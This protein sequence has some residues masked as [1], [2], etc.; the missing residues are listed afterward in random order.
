MDRPRV[1]VT[2]EQCWHDVPGGT[3]TSALHT[4]AALGAAGRFEPIGVSARHTSPPAEAFRPSVPVRP[5]PLPRPALYES[6]HRLRR[7]SLRRAV[8]D[9]AVAYVTGV[10]VPPSDVPLVVTVHDLAFV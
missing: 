2:L 9:A 8:P 3:A 1:A 6:W 4:V 10:A 5:L 7:P